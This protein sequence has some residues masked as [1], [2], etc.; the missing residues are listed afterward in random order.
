MCYN[1]IILGALMSPEISKKHLRIH[2]PPHFFLWRVRWYHIYLALRGT[3][4]V[5][6]GFVCAR[7]FLWPPRL[8]CSARRLGSAAVSGAAARGAA[9][10]LGSAAARRRSA[11][12]TERGTAWRRRSEGGGESPESPG[13]S[14]L[15]PGSLARRRLAR[16]IHHHRIKKISAANHTNQKG[17]AC[18]LRLI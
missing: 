3:Q 18:D 1:G 7:D 2:F 17:S 16:A 9:W 4:L 15:A 10:R 8:G 11:A 12:S 14:F 5:C 6:Q 13:T